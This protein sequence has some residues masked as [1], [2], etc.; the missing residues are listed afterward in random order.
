MAEELGKMSVGRD[1]ER[2]NA[3]WGDRGGE[4]GGRERNPHGLLFN[5]REENSTFFP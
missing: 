1:E 4:R 3:G 5:R 2:G